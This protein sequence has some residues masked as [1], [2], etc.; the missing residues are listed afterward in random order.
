MSFVP[1]EPSDGEEKDLSSSFLATLYPLEDIASF[2][3]IYDAFKKKNPKADHYPYAYCLNGM[4][5]SSDDGEPGGSAGRP[6]MSLLQDKGI[7]GLL[8]VARYFGGSKLGIPRLRRAFL[9]AGEDAI[10]HARLGEY[11]PIYVYSIEVDYPIYETLKNNAKRHSFSIESATFDINVR[12]E[13][14]SGGRLDGLGEAIGV[15][16][17]DLGEPQ[18]IPML[19]EVQL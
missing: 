13:I 7:D 11:R 19:Q 6:M 17:L 5:K 16:D 14:H 4:S 2:K 1:L 3:D 8:I 15:Y 10:A 12:A 18:I 9:A